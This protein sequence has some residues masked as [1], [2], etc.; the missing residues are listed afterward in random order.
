MSQGEM[1]S[2]NGMMLW[3]CN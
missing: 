1:H 3:S 2:T